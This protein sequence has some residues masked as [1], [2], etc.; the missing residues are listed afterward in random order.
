MITALSRITNWFFPHISCPVAPRG[1]GSGMP[2]PN[3]ERRAGLLWMAAGFEFGGMVIGGVVVGWWIDRWLAV[4]PWGIVVGLFLGAGGAF[5]RL[6]MLLQAAESA[7]DQRN[8]E[9]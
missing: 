5:Y 3:G 4:A 9:P 7:P 1:L 8:G 6:W 2:Q